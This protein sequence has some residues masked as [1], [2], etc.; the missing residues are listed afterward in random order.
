MCPL[1]VCVHTAHVL[2][3][4]FL[5]SEWQ[6]NYF[7]SVE[8]GL[9]ILKFEIPVSPCVFFFA[10]PDAGKVLIRSAV[11]RDT[12]E[13]PQCAMLLALFGCR[14]SINYRTYSARWHQTGFVVR[15]LALCVLM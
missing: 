2:L 1:H 3:S 10:S 14:W 5:I 4:D 11:T 13:V 9:G 15:D 12:V 8:T 6:E 7:H